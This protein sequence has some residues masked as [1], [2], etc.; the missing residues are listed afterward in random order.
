MSVIHEDGHGLERLTQAERML[1]EVASAQDA[2]QIRDMAEAARVWAQ[3]S[4]L[5]TASVNHATAIKLKA[6][7]R[8]ADLVDEG[9]AAGQIASPGGD[10]Q[11]IISPDDNAP[12]T[13]TDLG[14]TAQSVHEARRIRDAYTPESVDELVE[15]ANEQDK[16]LTRTEFVKGRA[17][18]AYNGGENEWYTPVRYL[19]AARATMGSIDLDPASSITAQSNVR[20]T[21]FYTKD[22]DGLNRDWH[23]NVWLNPPYA[24]PLIG[25][26]VQKLQDEFREGRVTQAV[27]LTNNAT[28]TAWGNSLLEYADSVC[29]LKGRIKFLNSDNVEAHTPL[30]GQMVTYM[31]RE[32]AAFRDAFGPMGVVL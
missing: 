31:G 27:V 9:Q 16:V 32:S 26:F 24:A 22:D 25:L 10:R 4:R 11:S 20:A 28:E 19:N 6:E 29:F 21:K 7:M 5:G 18:V 2:I 23:G 30:Q 3:R 12:A 14:L 15:S 1:A 13:L 17:H 8:I